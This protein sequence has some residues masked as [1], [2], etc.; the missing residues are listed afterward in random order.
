MSGGLSGIFSDSSSNLPG[1]VL[2]IYV[3]LIIANV[4]AWLWVLAAFHAYPVLLGTAFLAYTFGVRHA[5]DADHIA[6]IDN[7]TRKLMQEGKRPVAVGLFFS[8]GHSTVVTGLSIAIA[9]TTAALQSHFEMFKSVGGVIGTLVS[10]LFLFSIA[11]A[12][13]LVLV[14]VYRVFRIVKGGGRFIEEDL[15]LMLASRGFF[16][17]IFRRLFRVIERSWHMYPLGLLFGLGFDTATEVGLLGI[18]ATQAAQGMSAWTILVFPALFT[19][20]MTLV[21]TTDSILM[22]GAYGW[23][24]V[25]PIRKLYYNLTITTVSVVIAVI[26]GGL[27]T[28]NLIGDQLNLTD[29]GGFWGIVGALNDNFGILGYVIVGIFVAAWLLSYAIYRLNRYDEI[30]VHPA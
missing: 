30:E 11:T 28:L 15:D 5:F 16:S 14:S 24:F 8:L 18:S 4:A 29:S 9:V 23:A 10:A 19:A 3:L 2:G 13:V 17:R 22:L 27:E 21:D 20:G 26:V 12:N 6:A 25:K 7:V 1:K